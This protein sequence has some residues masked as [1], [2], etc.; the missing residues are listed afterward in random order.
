MQFSKREREYAQ[1]L[2]RAA[3]AKKYKFQPPVWLFGD[4]FCD[5]QVFTQD[6]HDPTIEAKPFPDKPYIRWMVEQWRAYRMNIW[7]KSRQIMA[8]WTLCALYLHD[9]QF[10]VGR[11][12]FIQSKKE[13]DSD[14]LL[15]RCYFIWLHQEEWLRALYPAEYSYCH[16]RF[17]KPGQQGGLP[18][19]ELH[20]IPQGGDVIRQYTG[21]GLFSD[22]AAFQDELEKAL[23]AAR[24][25]IAGGGR[26]DVVSSAEPGHFQELAEDR[27]K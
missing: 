9:T 16:L 20:A 2:L 21:S 4:R 14:A 7:E 15:R 18:Y 10:Q 3:K 12:N 11:R 23:G 24:P 27:I 6:E 22:E 5:R 17:F 1:W 8:S 25:M 19:S 13:L 26:I